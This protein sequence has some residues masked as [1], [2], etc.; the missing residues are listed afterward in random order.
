MD[1]DEKNTNNI[2]MIVKRVISEINI[3]KS[4]IFKIVDNVSDEFQVKNEELQ[5]VKREIEEV[6]GKVDKLQVLDKN[7]RLTL[8]EVSKISGEKAEKI[9]KKAYEE[10]IEIRVEYITKQNEE[11]NLKRRRNSL[12]KTLK[13]YLKNIEEADN[14]VNQ[15]NIA[16]GY[17]EGDMANVEEDSQMLIGIKI[18]ESQERERKRIAREIHDGP[19]QYIANTM[20]RIDFCKMVVQKDLNKGLKELDDLKNN[21][22]KALKEVRGILFDLRPLSLE[23]RGL[24]EAIKDMVNEISIESNICVNVTLNAMNYEIEHIIEIAVYRIIQEILNNI[25]KHSKANEVSVRI[26]C[27]KEYISFMVK[28]DGIGFDLKETMAKNKEKGTSYGLIGIFDRVT[29]LQG[30][31]DIKSA[32]NRGTIYKIKLP[33][34]REVYKN[35][36]K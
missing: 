14:T 23:E 6:I 8:A 36:R 3:G 11:K 32:H 7:M 16:L 24:N 25:K 13:N 18:L 15:I 35:E 2:N 26:E 27:G 10:A 20:M 28:D 1:N 31:I 4:N 5:E 30:H 19:A 33:I 21:V 22:R 29:Q 17:L 34:N 9:M 12:E